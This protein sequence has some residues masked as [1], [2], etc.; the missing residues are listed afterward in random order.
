MIIY[1]DGRLALC[2]YDWEEHRNIGDVNTMTLKEAWDS[3]EYESVRHMHLC[4]QFDKG[5]CAECHHWKIDYTQDGFIGTSYH[6]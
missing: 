4:N 6:L 2:N 3:K 5:I 1:W